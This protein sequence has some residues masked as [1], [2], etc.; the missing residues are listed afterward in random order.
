[1]AWRRPGDKPLSEPRMES[2]LTHI[3]VIRPQWVNKDVKIMDI[4]SYWIY[5]HL[6]STY[7]CLIPI[8]DHTSPSVKTT[9]IYNQ[10]ICFHL[11]IQY[12]VSVPFLQ[13]VGSSAGMTLP[14]SSHNTPICSWKG[15][16]F[17]GNKCVRKCVLTYMWTRPFPLSNLN[18]HQG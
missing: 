2:L 7:L 6:P 9:R 17:S 8:T 18:E 14:D 4:Y 1:M 11:F 12:R 5:I 16:E 3:C 15:G 10:E 13:G